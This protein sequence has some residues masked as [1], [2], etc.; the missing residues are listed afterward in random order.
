MYSLI[1]SQSNWL[2]SKFLWIFCLWT[3]LLS[4]NFNN[5]IWWF[6]GQHLRRQHPGIFPL[7]LPTIPGMQSEAWTKL[8][9]RSVGKLQEV[10][11]SS[12][13]TAYSGT[14]QD[15]VALPQRLLESFK[16]CPLIGNVR[17]ATESTVYTFFTF[18]TM[19][20]FTVIVNT[21]SCVTYSQR[22]I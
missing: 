10:I 3:F 9:V 12:V 6:P 2:V 17:T 11:G 21:I 18:Y 15:V 13:R 1:Q 7:R 19:E 14:M 22:L 5:T 16:P 8:D 4:E 20:D